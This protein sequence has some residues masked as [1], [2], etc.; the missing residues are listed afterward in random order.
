MVNTSVQRCPSW[1][2]W[3]TLSS[4]AAVI[5][6]AGLLHGGGQNDSDEWATAL[7]IQLC[8]GQAWR[9]HNWAGTPRTIA[10]G[11]VGRQPALPTQLVGLTLSPSRAHRDFREQR[12][13][14]DGL[15]HI[16][17]PLLLSPA[18]VTPAG[19]TGYRNTR[20]GRL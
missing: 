9:M 13:G 4:P 7:T 18:P 10:L 17:A 3:T 12:A 19:S 16:A 11:G 14:A 20:R 2:G 1:V 5:E 8:G 6:S 15:A